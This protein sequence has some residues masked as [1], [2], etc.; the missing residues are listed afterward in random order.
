[1]TGRGRAAAGVPSDYLDPTQL[2]IDLRRRSVEL[3]LI[4]PRV[5][6]TDRFEFEFSEIEAA[7]SEGRSSTMA[8]TFRNP[9]RSTDPSSV[10]DG[11]KSILSF[12]L[13]YPEWSTTGMAKGSIA[14]Y[15]VRDY[16]QQLRDSL[17][18]LCT[19]IVDSG[20]RALS[21]L[22]Q[23]VT[24]DKGAARRSGLGWMGKNTL[25]LTNKTGPYLVLGEI[26]TDCIFVRDQPSPK[27][28]GNCQRCQ[29]ACPTGALNRAYKLDA[30]LCLSWLLQKAG[31]FPIELRETLGLRFYGCDDCLISC[32]VGAKSR[33]VY[34]FEEPF[35]PVFWLEHDDAALLSA[36]SALYIPKR[37]PGHLRRNLLLILGNHAACPGGG[38]AAIERH[39]THPDPVVRGTAAW[40]AGRH[41][42]VNLLSRYHESEPSHEVRAEIESALARIYAAGRPEQVEPISPG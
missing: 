11:A 29:V 19:M 20:Y 26:F 8:F 34:S 27:G 38:G 10:L 5:A 42:F 22:D 12:G 28:C 21:V 35:D 24:V 41:G 4:G 9:P 37:D 2:L 7:L 36:F 17:S 1:M 40:T 30:R 32:P 31:S 15:A 18:E 6:S 13:G 25:I 14:S 39:L 23:N 33:P 3:G 16:Y